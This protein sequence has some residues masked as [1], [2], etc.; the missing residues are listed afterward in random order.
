MFLIVFLTCGRQNLYIKQFYSLKSKIQDTPYNLMPILPLF[1]WKWIIILFLSFFSFLKKL[2]RLIFGQAFFFLNIALKGLIFLFPIIARLEY[3]YLN[4]VS[5]WPHKPD[6]YLSKDTEISPPF[7]K[8]KTE[9][10]TFQIN[11]FIVITCIPK[12]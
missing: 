2:E 4:Y 12:R 10:F 11:I 5:L 7:D 8:H 9:K 1:N 6:G 3:V